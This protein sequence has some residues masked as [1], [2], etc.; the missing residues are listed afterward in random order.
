MTGED[1]H[2]DQGNG[3]SCAC[4]RVLAEAARQL[5]LRSVGCRPPAHPADPP[6]Q[7]AEFGR[8]GGVVAGARTAVGA[9]HQ[10][11]AMGVVAAGGATAVPRRQPQHVAVLTFAGYDTAG[12]LA[13]G[14]HRPCRRSTAGGIR[15]SG[16]G[17]GVEMFGI[18][19]AAI[20][21]F[22]G[23]VTLIVTTFDGDPTAVLCADSHIRWCVLSGVVGSGQIACRRR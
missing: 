1:R 10:F 4:G 9:P 6:P 19:R 21:R 13:R 11:E 8:A 22:I 20:P 18:V 17:F 3:S 15:S 16:S 23:G 2:R 5:T 14:D 12:V 7:R